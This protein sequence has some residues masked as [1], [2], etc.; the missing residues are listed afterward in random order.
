M[1]PSI[2][3]A[4]VAGLCWGI[5]EVCSKWVLSSHQIGP[6]TAIT[7][8]STIALPILWAVY[9]VTV[10]VR[11]DTTEG[12]IGNLQRPQ[13]LALICGS[14]LLAGALAM[15]F[16]YMSMK[17]APISVVKPIAFTLSPAVAVLLGWAVL[18]EGMTPVKGCAVS[19]ILLGV[20]LLTVGAK[21]APEPK[22][23]DGAQP[24][25]AVPTETAPAPVPAPAPAAA[26]SSAPAPT[27]APRN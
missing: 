20:I 10:H 19:L 23:A 2:I 9:L 12:A 16:F 6:I 8:R 14:G 1:L 25:L 21:K 13:W 27:N 11:H 15:I 18:K 3:L 5:G 26:P 17:G 22:A 7:L 24:A 4:I